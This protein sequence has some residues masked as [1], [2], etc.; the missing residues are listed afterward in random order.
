MH[1]Q[2]KLNYVIYWQQG[3]QIKQIVVGRLSVLAWGRDGKMDGDFMWVG[4]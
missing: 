2:N 3:R 4:L 1:T